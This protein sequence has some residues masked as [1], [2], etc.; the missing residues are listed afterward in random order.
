MP[1]L[2]DLLCVSRQKYTTHDPPNRRLHRRQEEPRT[3]DDQSEADYDTQPHYS[4]RRGAE[5][6]SQDSLIWLVGDGQ[7]PRREPMT[8]IVRQGREGG[9]ELAGGVLGTGLKDRSSLDRSNHRKKQPQQQTRPLSQASNQGRSKKTKSNEKKK[10]DCD[11]DGKRRHVQDIFL[12]DSRHRDEARHSR[13][14][15][16]VSLTP[17][18]YSAHSGRSKTRRSQENSRPRQQT[19]SMY[20]YTPRS[21]N[22]SAISAALFGNRIDDFVHDPGWNRAMDRFAASPTSGSSLSFSEHSVPSPDEPTASPYS[23]FSS[24]QGD[25]GN[26]TRSSSRLEWSSPKDRNR[27]TSGSPSHVILTSNL[28]D[29]SSSFYVDG[30]VSDC[31]FDWRN[32]DYERGGFDVGVLGVQGEVDDLDEVQSGPRHALDIEKLFSSN[33]DVLY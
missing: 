12:D 32:A 31:F 28:S 16:S 5:P 8:E 22:D 3:E 19:E 17:S 13:N 29:S 9:E 6:Y 18:S 33:G 1:S 23:R 10:Q 4:F 27:T 2:W 24:S 14:T 7:C 30:K 21:V 25:Y 15:S 11:A 26:V 20:Q